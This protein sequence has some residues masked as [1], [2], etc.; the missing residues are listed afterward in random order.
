MK[1][2]TNAIAVVVLIALIAY[3]WLGKQPLEGRGV[4]VFTCTSTE[5]RSI[6]E[7]LAINNTPQPA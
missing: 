5:P 3:L 2:N 4:N 1:L 7:F 6:N